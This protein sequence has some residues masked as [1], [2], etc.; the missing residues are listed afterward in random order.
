M[1]NKN[2]SKNKISN[3]LDNKFSITKRGSTIKQ[4]TIGGVINF[5]VMVY[6]MIVIPNILTG[7][8]LHSEQ[9]WNALFLATIITVI[10]TTLALAFKANLPLVSAPGI[11]LSSYFATL[12][13]NGVYTFSQ[14][15]TIALLASLI[16]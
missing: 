5:L 2:E 8:G 11:G 7:G 4:E 12:M 1:V 3:Y 10:I 15:L 6:V 9:V 16:F 13:Q 14:T